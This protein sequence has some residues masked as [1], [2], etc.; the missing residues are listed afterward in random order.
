MKRLYYQ[1]KLPIT[2]DQAWDFFSSPKNLNEITPPDFTFEFLSDIP[3]N[4]Y[5]GL[6]IQYRVR[7]MLHIPIL[8]TTEI[9]HVVDKKYFV[10]EQ[11]QGPYNIWHHEHHF[12]ATENGV[13]M[14][15]ILHYDIG[16]SFIGWLAGKL[17]VDQK[18]KGIFDY[19]HKKLERLFGSI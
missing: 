8:W 6:L 12:E 19:R 10:D 2:L 18:V 15:D 3:Q 5:P 4:M 14:T 13:L 7:P 16:M 1:Q 9:T 11:R 17:F